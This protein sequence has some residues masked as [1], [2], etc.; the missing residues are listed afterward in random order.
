[1]ITEIIQELIQFFRRMF[2]WHSYRITIRRDNG[3]DYYICKKC[4]YIKR[5]SNDIP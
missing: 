3:V 1:M 4:G 5:Y 2:C